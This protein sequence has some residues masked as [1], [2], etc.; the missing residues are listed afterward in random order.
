MREQVST[1]IG[2]DTPQRSS[3]SS[4]RSAASGTRITLI[5]AG[6][7]G[8]VGGQVLADSDSAPAKMDNH[9]DRPEFQAAL[10]GRTGAPS[11]TAPRWTRR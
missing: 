10:Q 2:S 1:H 11:A 8:L 6:L 9:S 3:R 5:A 4:A 7:P